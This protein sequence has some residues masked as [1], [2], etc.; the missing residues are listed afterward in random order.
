[1][2]K[3]IQIDCNKDGVYTIHGYPFC[4]I[5]GLQETSHLFRNKMRWARYARKGYY[6]AGKD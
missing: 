3:C 5:H 6:I 2:K 1:M 4:L